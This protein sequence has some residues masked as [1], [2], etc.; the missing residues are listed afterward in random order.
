MA[1]THISSDAMGFVAQVAE[2]R[3]RGEGQHKMRGTSSIK[4]Y[5]R[6]RHEDKK[7]PSDIH[8]RS[9]PFFS[10]CFVPGKKHQDFRLDRANRAQRLQQ[11]LRPIFSFDSIGV[12][13]QRVLHSH[14]GRSHEGADL[15]RSGPV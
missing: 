9:T 4:T 10:R 2:G 14:P 13:V 3:M 5:G 6:I 1:V 7:H 8:E 11:P 15:R 12:T